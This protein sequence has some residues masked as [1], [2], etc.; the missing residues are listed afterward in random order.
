MEFLVKY[1]LNFM[2]YVGTAHIIIEG[3][4]YF[5]LTLK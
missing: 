5:S 2:G 4:L 3:I 1:Y